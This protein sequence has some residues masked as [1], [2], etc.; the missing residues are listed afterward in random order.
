MAHLG[1]SANSLSPDIQS[2]IGR[3]DDSP[4]SG[5]I[6]F[7]FLFAAKESGR[8]VWGQEGGISMDLHLKAPPPS[9]S[10]RRG[11]EHRD[12]RTAEVCGGNP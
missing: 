5:Y 11:G 1:I 2:P 12:E 8:E 6:F 4:A 9:A 7:L 3:Q 10:E